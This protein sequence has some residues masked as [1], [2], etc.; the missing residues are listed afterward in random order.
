MAITRPE[1]S[2]DNVCGAEIE[3]RRPWQIILFMGGLFG[4]VFLLLIG[5]LFW[6]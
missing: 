6:W 3:L 5:D 4:A 2:A 1:W